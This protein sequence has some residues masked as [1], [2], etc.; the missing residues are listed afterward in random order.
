M[1]LIQKKIQ[2]NYRKNY[3]PVSNP[4]SCS[5]NI[6]LLYANLDFIYSGRVEKPKNITELFTKML[7]SLDIAA[8]IFNLKTQKSHFQNELKIN[9][10]QK[11][12]KKI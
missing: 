9:V 2:K 11:Y 3:K 4:L 5:K 1:T 10:L 12:Y 6:L 7:G 8:F